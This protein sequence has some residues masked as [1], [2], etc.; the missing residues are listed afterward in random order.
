MFDSKTPLVSILTPAYNAGQFI[1]YA[2]DSVINQSYQKW[3]LLVIDDGSTDNTGEIVNGFQKTEKRI[4]YLKQQ[5]SGTGAAR[6]L[7]LRHASGELVGFL[8]SDDV[9]LP[10]KLEV[11]VSAILDKKGHLVLS[12]G[13]FT[14][15]L[16]SKWE[17]PVQGFLNKDCLPRL[18]GFN[19][20][21]LLSVVIRKDILLSLGGFS[22][23]RELWEVADYDLWI[24]FFYNNYSGFSLNE[25]FLFKY[26]LHEF[27]ST[28]KKKSTEILQKIILMLDL[29]RRN[30]II[31]ESI[32]KRSLQE[33]FRRFL[34]RHFLSRDRAKIEEILKIMVY[35]LDNKVSYCLIRYVSQISLK[36]GG[37]LSWR[38][39]KSGLIT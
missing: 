20:V 32:Y 24:R 34:E 23:S 16:K 27:Q 13:Y 36:V 17:V 29:H 2:I 35:T 4:K 11:Q 9:W 12:A 26:R 25:H 39:L 30:G 33:H 21:P 3:E 22:D 5:N 1:S 8:D 15:D 31:N 10:N 19:F 6:N 28:D 38:L 18:L 7:G 14:G 37:F